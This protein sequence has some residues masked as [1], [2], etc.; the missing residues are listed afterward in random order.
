MGFHRLLHSRK[1][2]FFQAVGP[3]AIP[4]RMPTKDWS[5]ASDA[6]F[7]SFFQKPLV[8]GNI[9]G[10]CNS[11]V[12]MAGLRFYPGFARIQ[13]DAAATLF[14]LGDYPFIP[15]SF[16]IYKGNRVSCLSAKDLQ[17]VA[18]FFSAESGNIAFNF[19][20]MEDNH[21]ANVKS[22]SFLRVFL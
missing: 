1:Q 22:K 14:R 15:G 11:H 9:F 17:T 2:D 5:N 6:H 10:G 3:N 8:T 19:G 16:T 20:G 13:F 18:G 12:Q 4:L 7:C 21:K